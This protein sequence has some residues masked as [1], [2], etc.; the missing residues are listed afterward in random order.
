MNSFANLAADTNLNRDSLVEIVFLCILEFRLEKN[1]TSVHYTLGHI[2]PYF[3]YIIPSLIPSLLDIMILMFTFTFLEMSSI[4]RVLNVL[5]IKYSIYSCRIL[6]G[7][8][9]ILV[10]P[11][12]LCISTRKHGIIRLF[13]IIV[14]I[15][16]NMSVY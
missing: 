9:E 4:Q 14:L 16:V 7:S 15:L 6:P 2:P 1:T 3:G 5:Y 11:R 13:Y 12:I 8:A 10:T